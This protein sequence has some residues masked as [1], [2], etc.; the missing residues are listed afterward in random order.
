MGVELF[1]PTSVRIRDLVGFPIVD[2]DV[3]VGANINADKIGTGVVDNTEFDRLN[4]IT[5]ALEEQG[6][7]GAVSGYAGLD[8]SQELL[9]TN[10]PSGAALQVLRRNAGNTALEFADP[11]GAGQTHWATDI[12]AAKKKR[13]I[14]VYHIAGTNVIIYNRARH[15][16]YFMRIAFRPENVK[17]FFQIFVEATN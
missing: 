2:A 4:G 17:K 8:A 13:T 6:N 9:L 12:D 10:F 14:Y 1:E 3:A 15:G 16:V 7:K 5:S 11:N